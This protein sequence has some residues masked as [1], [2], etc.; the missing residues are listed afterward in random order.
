M[1]ICMATLDKLAQK[2][3]LTCEAK[4]FHER[5]YI[6]YRN[7]SGYEIQLVNPSIDSERLALIMSEAAEC[8]EALR[9]DDDALAEEELADVIIRCLHMAECHGWSMDDAVEAKMAKE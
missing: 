7:A 2:I 8:L 6:Y 5:H 4:G 9:K 1:V 3:W